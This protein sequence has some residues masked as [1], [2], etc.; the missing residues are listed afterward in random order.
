MTISIVGDLNLSTILHMQ[1]FRTVLNLD[2]VFC[3]SSTLASFDQYR[4]LLPVGTQ[5]MVVGN[6]APILG[7]Q[8]LVADVGLSELEY[9]RITKRSF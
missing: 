1:R 7:D 4:T 9:L 3:P 6:L 2:Y 5:Y 8:P